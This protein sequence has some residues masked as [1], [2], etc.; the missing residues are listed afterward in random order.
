MVKK[1]IKKVKFSSSKSWKNFTKDTVDEMPVGDF[2]VDDEIGEIEVTMTKVKI[3]QAA[4]D[5]LAGMSLLAVATK[6]ELEEE[7]MQAIY[8]AV[9]ERRA[10]VN[11]G[12]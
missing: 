4:A 10:Q 6:Y 7:D 9:A 8:E 5:I 11:S 1:N 3:K 12:D 2:V